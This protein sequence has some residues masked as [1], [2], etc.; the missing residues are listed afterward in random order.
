MIQAIGDWCFIKRDEQETM[1]S[2]MAVS[3]KAQVK[4]HIGTVFSAGNDKFVTKG[5]RTLIP[6]YR[7]PDYDV[8]GEEFA[9]PKVS[10]LF[11]VYKNGSFSP[12]NKFVKVLKCQN[13]D[14]LSTG[15]SQQPL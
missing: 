5:D 11:A 7:V 3:E 2:G 10:D 9:V 6:H 8:D 13:D 12:V 1:F 4:S 15:C 14:V